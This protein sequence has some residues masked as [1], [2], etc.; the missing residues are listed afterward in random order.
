MGSSYTASANLPT[1]NQKAA[2]DGANSPSS[3]NVFATIADIDAAITA[4]LQN[5]GTFGSILAAAGI[6]PTG[7]GAQTPVTTITTES[8][9]VTDKG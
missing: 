7:D 5:D 4:L 1:A 8:G 6:T 2:L 3:G 9:I